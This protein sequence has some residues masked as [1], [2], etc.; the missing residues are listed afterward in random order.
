VTNAEVLRAAALEFFHPEAGSALMLVDEFN[1]TPEFVNGHLRGFE[2][3]YH[4]LQGLADF[5]SQTTPLE[6]SHE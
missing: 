6:G 4:I 2:D 3:A 5:V 1:T